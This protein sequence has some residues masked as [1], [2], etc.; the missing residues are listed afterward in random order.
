MSTELKRSIRWSIALITL[1]VAVLYGG[2]G[3]AAVL[4]PAALAVW[5]AAKPTLGTGRN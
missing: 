1:G 2:P 4:V 3:W 5:Y